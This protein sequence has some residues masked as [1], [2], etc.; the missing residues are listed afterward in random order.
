MV[1]AFHQAG[2]LKAGIAVVEAR[3]A[4]VRGVLAELTAKLEV[5]QVDLAV[6]QTEA[7]RLKTA[8]VQEARE[9]ALSEREKIEA[10]YKDTAEG[11]EKL[12]VET[13]AKSDFLKTIN[14]QI[15]VARREVAKILGR[16][17]G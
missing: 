8:A 16:T 12:K 15:A 1:A 10:A 14:D 11:L 13:Q 7:R 3:V 9:A 5:A 4:E 17:N 2:S 6:K